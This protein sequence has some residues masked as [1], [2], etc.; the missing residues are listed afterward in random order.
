MD[1]QNTAAGLGLSIAIALVVAQV[2]ARLVRYTLAAAS[3]SQNRN[4]FSEPI[5]R[6]PIRVVRAVVFFVILGLATRPVLNL[7]DVDLTFGIPLEELTAWLFAQGTACG[8]DR[9]AR[10][11]HGS[12]RSTRHQSLRGYR[13]SHGPETTP[14]RLN[15]SSVFTQSVA[16]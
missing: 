12:C 2:A 6:R 5:T 10:I 14:T 7:F 15:L 16:W 11:F 8:F 9:T 3:G 4:P 13:Q 1:W